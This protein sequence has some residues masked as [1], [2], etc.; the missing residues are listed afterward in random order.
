MPV[1]ALVDDCPLYDLAPERP[2]GQLY[3]APERTLDGRRT[4]ARETLLALLASPNIASR[5]PLFEQYDCM[6]G[7]RT[8]RRPE[9]ADAAVLMIGRPRDRR[10]DRRQRPP[11]R[12][13]PVHGRDRGGAR[14]RGEPGLRRRRAAGA[15]E[16]PELRQPREA[17]HRVA[18]DRG[19]PRPGRRVPRARTCRSSAATS[20]STTR[21]PRGRSTRRRS[22]AWSASCPTRRARRRAASR[23]TATRSCSSAT[24]RPRCAGERA[25]QA[26]AASRCPTA[27]RRPTSRPSARRTR[28]SRGAVRSGAARSCHDIAEGGLAVALAECCLL[29]GTARERRR[30][31]DRPLRR[32]AGPRVPGLAARAQTSST[33]AASRHRRRLRA[34]HRRARVAAGR[35]A[36]GAR[37]AR[38]AVSLS[39]TG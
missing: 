2:S 25:G 19:R 23:A 5:R 26:A 3:P 20:R 17:A 1:D 34:S 30:G 13:R 4:S 7:S 9:Q 12:S 36:R 18:A 28:R 15:D 16:L 8:A 21:A 22:W 24:S 35:A 32:A 29:G 10:V 39:P 14:V 33:S 38:A 37:R 11:R 31:R 6:V 27:C